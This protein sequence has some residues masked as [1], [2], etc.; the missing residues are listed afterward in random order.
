MRP[1][2]TADV[3]SC[4]SGRPRASRPSDLPTSAHGAGAH[5]NRP[6]CRS[7][8]AILGAIGGRCRATQTD[9]PRRFV[10]LNASRT[11]ARRRTAKLRRCLLSSGSRVRILPGAQLRG[12]LKGLP[13]RLGP[14][15]EPPA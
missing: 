10:K 2:P 6:R 3:R 5:P 1:I 15:W 7:K 13:A 12:H 11:D 4:R 8:G 9:T 14:D